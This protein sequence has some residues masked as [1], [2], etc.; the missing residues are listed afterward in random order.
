[1]PSASKNTSTC[2]GNSTANIN[3]C[4]SLL[5]KKVVTQSNGVTLHDNNNTNETNVS[6]QNNYK[7]NTF[8]EVN[9]NGT[10]IK[11]ETNTGTCID[12]NCIVGM[13]SER[14]FSNMPQFQQYYR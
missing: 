1:M 11:Q 6:T 9:I 14:V 12:L 13:I 10:P 2:K 4:K 3:N 5:K 7:D 8:E